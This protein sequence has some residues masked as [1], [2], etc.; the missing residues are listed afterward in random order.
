MKLPSKDYPDELA[1]VGDY[2]RTARTDR[3]LTQVEAA[4][5][6]G[7]DTETIYRWELRGHEP[8]VSAWRGIVQFLG[9][10]PFKQETLAEHLLAYRRRHGIKQEVLAERLEVDPGSVRRW[11]AGKEPKNERCL[12]A[13]AKLLDAGGEEV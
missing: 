4:A 7:V 12:S 11:E 2:I 6:I 3:G 10:Y 8:V 9:F 1:C 13:I 5:L